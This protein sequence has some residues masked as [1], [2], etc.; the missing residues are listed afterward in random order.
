M[1]KN[2]PDGFTVFL[3]PDPLEKRRRWDIAGIWTILNQSLTIEANPSY[4]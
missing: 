4:L 1:A 2:I 3:L